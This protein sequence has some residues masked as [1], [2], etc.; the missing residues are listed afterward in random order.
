MAEGRN[1]NTDR[2]Y[3]KNN[4]NG[5]ANKRKKDIANTTTTHIEMD[6]RNG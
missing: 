1:F 4:R 2:R 3:N 5:Y 6:D